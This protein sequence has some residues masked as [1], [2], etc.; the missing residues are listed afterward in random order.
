MM[1]AH[2]PSSLDLGR[3]VT[4]EGIEGC[5]KTTQLERL[6]ERLAAV[7]VAAVLTREPGGTALG[8]SLRSVLLS[9]D[10]ASMAPSTEL[11]LYAADRAQ[12]LTEV[13]EPALAA[14][15]VVLCD[16][17][18]DATLAYQG[19]GRELGFEAVLE[20]HR[21][22]PLD[23]RPDRT[24]LLDLDPAEALERARRRNDELD[25][26]ATEGRFEQERLAFHRR[27]REGYLALAAAE[28]G[29]FVVIDA[30]GTAAEV[31][32]RILAG[33]RDLLAELEAR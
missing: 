29:R 2:D 10:S 11:L 31:E 17:Y 30:R 6:A 23:R 27:V 26:D 32:T 24:L 14:G 20:L 12:H 16:R 13:V 18:L 3:F 22:P 9:P 7:G 21:R 19:Y 28:P 1:S 4:F 33:V 5:G 8:R 15:R 25:L